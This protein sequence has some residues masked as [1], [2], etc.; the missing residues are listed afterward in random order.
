MGL[1]LCAGCGRVGFDA[2]ATFDARTADGVLR[3]DRVDP[4]E[5]LV[6]FPLPVR[7]PIDPTL[8]F[9]FQG[10]PLPYEIDDDL[11]WVRVPEIR[12]LSTLIELRHDG[13]V[14]PDPVW[15]ADHEAVWHMGAG[16]LKDSTGHDHVGVMVKTTEVP[17]QIGLG[18]QFVKAMQSYAEIPDD[19]TLSFSKITMSAWRREPANASTFKAI[20]GRQLTTTTQ[21]DYYLGINGNQPL[22]QVTVDQSLL[23]YGAAVPTDTW[24]HF[25]S[26][27]DGTTLTL[28]IDGEVSGTPL[29]GNGSL[30][31]SMQR[32][33]LGAD[34]DDN[35]PCPNVDFQDAILD[36][37][38]IERVAR[39]AAWIRYEV[40]SGRDE[41]ITYE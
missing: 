8:S 36:E 6:D 23:L 9:Y 31:H 28:Y 27:Y 41:V 11:Y 30:T 25:A 26:T 3:L 15:T 39:S 18:Q 19:P 1:L 21:D 14:S 16:N 32:T 10:A 22:T 12:G 40:A 24:V 34:C 17:A 20:I 7:L 13:A 29:T 33:F 4:V 2:A 37:I 38:R 35:G 5:V